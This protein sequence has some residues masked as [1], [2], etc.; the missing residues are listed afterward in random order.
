MHGFR[1]AIVTLPLW[2]ASPTLGDDFQALFNGKDLDG[3]VA[4]GQTE[5]PKDGVAR[6]VWSVREGLIHCDG[7][8][9]GF[10]RYDRH[11]YKDFVFHVDF[12]MAPGC[13]SGLGVRTRVF[14]PEQSRATRPS[15][16]SYEIQ[17]MDDAGKPATP[18]SSGSLYRYVAP[19]EN[20]IKPAS[21]W[22]S[23]DIE[24]VGP[25]I[26]VTLNGKTIID[27]DQQTVEAIK[28]KPMKGFVCLQNHGG[29]IDFRDVRIREIP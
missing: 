10:L 15:L 28:T 4:E 21:E 12:R 22:N 19:K 14:I 25:K 8:G 23:I 29:T 9:F 1:W 11:E 6:P 2:L 26:K 3:W 27:V 18:H 5:S 16:Y 20:A 13:N 7:K 17:L 24:C